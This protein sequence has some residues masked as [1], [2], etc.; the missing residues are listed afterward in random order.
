MVLKQISKGGDLI[1]WSID[2]LSTIGILL[3]AMLCINRWMEGI[4]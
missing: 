4:I 1:M 2:V 3:P